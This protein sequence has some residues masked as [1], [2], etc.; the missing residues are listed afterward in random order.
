MPHIP[1]LYQLSYREFTLRYGLFRE[2]IQ[3][4]I[5]NLDRCVP[6]HH[7]VDPRVIEVHLGFLTAPTFHI[8]I[9]CIWESP[10]FH[11]G[12]REY[13]LVSRHYHDYYHRW[14]AAV[15]AN[16]Q[17]IQR[18][19]QG[20]QAGLDYWWN[21][22]LRTYLFFDDGFLLDNYYQCL[23][24]KSELEISWYAHRTP[25]TI[26]AMAKAITQLCPHSPTVASL[27]DFQSL[28]PEQKERIYKHVEEDLDCVG[29]CCRY[30]FVYKALAYGATGPDLP[31]FRDRNYEVYGEEYWVHNLPAQ[32]LVIA[33]VC[34]FQVVASHSYANF[35]SIKDLRQVLLD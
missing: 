19:S 3:E 10:I 12:T 25:P 30:T 35:H 26:Y 23:P 20:L 31:P 16:N 22:Y 7:Q 33:T 13:L 32:T 1:T 11:I 17:S 29:A 27:P 34:Q 24:I 4:L 8:G 5:D 21:G 14:L 2:E 18:C 9:P 28:S 15:D 6:T